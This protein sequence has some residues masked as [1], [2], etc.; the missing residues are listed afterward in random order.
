MQ[1]SNNIPLCIDLDGTLLR[2]DYWLSISNAICMPTA[3]ATCWSKSTMSG[4]AT[5]SET[6]MTKSMYRLYL[7]AE[8]WRLS[9][10]SGTVR[11][12]CA[13]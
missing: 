10:Q 11:A 4:A 12:S 6:S 13:G 1:L 3:S 9:L 7:L 5:T 8:R 2:S